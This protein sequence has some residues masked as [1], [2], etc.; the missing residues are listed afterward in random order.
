MAV[1]W[2]GG[3]GTLLGR[4][5]VGHA[6]ALLHSSR[7]PFF[8]VRYGY[9]WHAGG[10]YARLAERVGA[11]YDHIDGVGAGAHETALLTD[12]VG[13]VVA[14]GEVR[15]GGPM[16]SRSFGELPEVASPLSSPELADDRFR[17]SPPPSEC[18]RTSSSISDSRTTS[19]L[20]G[21]ASPRR[22]GFTCGEAELAAHAGGTPGLMR[23]PGEASAPVTNFAR[24][25]PGALAE[26]R[27]P[28]FLFSGHSADGLALEMLQG[29]I[30]DLNR[31]RPPPACN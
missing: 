10:H 20:V 4:R 16:S 30:A 13:M 26:A 28:V 6:A 17:I 3:Q 27:F 24:S 14:P 23:R 12:K 29:L 18:P 25:S 8:S 7:C 5:A 19:P 31:N 9:S 11:S 2:I 1:A 22:C 21:Q 15:V